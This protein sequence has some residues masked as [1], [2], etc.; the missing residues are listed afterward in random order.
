VHF[1]LFCLY[2][3]CNLPCSGF[4]PAEWAFGFPHVQNVLALSTSMHHA[5]QQEDN[6]ALGIIHGTAFIVLQDRLH[7]RGSKVKALVAHPGVCATSLQTTS[8]ASG[9]RSTLNNAFMSIIMTL[10]QSEEDGAMPLLQCMCS[11]N[12]SSGKFV[13]PKHKGPIGTL[14]NDYWTGLPQEVQP[15][16]LS[17]HPVSKGMLWELSET[18]CG[19]F[20][21]AA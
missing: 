20:F 2:T 14:F 11:A 16:R 17:T 9:P 5:S 12:V 13:V 15:E 3:W 4:K 21:A 8:T 1:Q 18:A 10:A 7:Q 6:L 19:P